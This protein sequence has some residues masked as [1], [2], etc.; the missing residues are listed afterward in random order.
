MALKPADM[1]SCDKKKKCV[2]GPNN[3]LAYSPL[4]PCEQGVFDEERCDCVSVVYNECRLYKISWTEERYD[5]SVCGGS[6]SADCAEDG[7]VT[8]YKEATVEC[9]HGGPYFKVTGQGSWDFGSATGFPGCPGVPGFAVSGTY[10]ILTLVADDEDGVSR[11]VRT[12]S[13]VPVQIYSPVFADRESGGGC[14]IFNWHI[15][16]DPQIELLCT[17]SLSCEFCD[18]SNAPIGTD[19]DNCPCPEG[20][21]R[22]SLCEC[23]PEPMIP[24]YYITGSTTPYQRAVFIGTNCDFI[25]PATGYGCKAVY[26]VIQ[27]STQTEHCSWTQIS[28]PGNFCNSDHPQPRPSEACPD[29]GVTTAFIPKDSWRPCANLPDESSAPSCVACDYDINGNP[30]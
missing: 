4:D 27:L 19:C 10:D 3:G 11:E 12:N 23:V 30:V 26:A 16:R 5:F 6:S 21:T 18:M 13:Q 17:R 22:N 1:Q 29:L 25:G 20:E 14:T 8:S 15:Y 7:V 2:G 24:V 9:L 28:A